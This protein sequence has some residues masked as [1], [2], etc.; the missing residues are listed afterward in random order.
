MKPVFLARLSCS[1]ECGGSCFEC[2]RRFGLGENC[3]WIGSIDALVRNLPL[4]PLPWPR[5]RLGVKLPL[6]PSRSTGL[7]VLR[8]GWVS[9]HMPPACWL[10]GFIRPVLKHGPR[11]LTYVRV[12]GWQTCMRNESDCWD[13]CT[14]N[15]PSNWVRFE[16]EHVRLL[17][18]RVIPRG[19]V[20]KGSFFF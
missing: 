10:N 12:C 7:P 6:L 3:G 19:R 11:S 16:Y 13:I 15:R 2:Q 17:P 20:T 8:L 18:V 1:T 14:N 5:R 9:A 4:R